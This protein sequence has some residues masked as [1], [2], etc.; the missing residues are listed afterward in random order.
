MTIDEVRKTRLD[1]CWKTGAICLTVLGAACV[2]F[3]QELFKLKNAGDI[4]VL[5]FSA[6]ILVVFLT[7]C[8]YLYNDLKTLKDDNNQSYLDAKEKISQAYDNIFLNLK[9]GGI[10][11]LIHTMLLASGVS[12][13]WEWMQSLA[14][15]IPVLCGALIISVLFPFIPYNK[16]IQC[17]PSPQQNGSSTNTSTPNTNTRNLT[18]Q[19]NFIYHV[20]CTTNISNGK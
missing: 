6:F 2:Y 13:Q 1:Y 20:D 15:Q 14:P 9:F 5:G 18:I 10:Y 16:Q 7:L 4:V 19:T 8:Y 17:V 3:Q 12:Y 11:L